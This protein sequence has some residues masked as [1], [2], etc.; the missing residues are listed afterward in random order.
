MRFYPTVIFVLLAAS[1]YPPCAAAQGGVLP[2]MMTVGREEAVRNL[3]YVLE[4]IAIRVQTLPD[5][6]H[7]TS[8]DR[9]KQFRDNQG[10]MR[11]ELYTERQGQMF[12]RFVQL[13]DPGSRTSVVLIASSKTAQVRHVPEP[14]PQTPEEQARRAAVRAEGAARRAAAISGSAGTGSGGSPATVAS[15]RPR[16]REVVELP[17]RTILGLRVEGKR[18]THI[19]PAGMIG[20][21]HE[22]STIQE[23]WSS[24]ELGIDLDRTT[25]DYAMGKTV[26]TVISLDRVEAN[27]ALFEIPA[28]Y[29]VHE[30]QMG[31]LG[32]PGATTGP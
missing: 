16:S 17:P 3:P 8:T 31:T 18:T 22:L 4:E 1:M 6:S 24:P 25:E 28:G 23:V 13:W 27:P 5:G 10:R 19:I 20:N 7:V 21:D 2:P 32:I 9:E 15:A 30:S 14:R 29:T 11:T 12:P 26:V